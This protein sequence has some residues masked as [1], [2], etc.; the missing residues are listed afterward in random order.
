MNTQK[1][2][3]YTNMIHSLSDLFPFRCQQATEFSFMYFSHRKKFPRL[4]QKDYL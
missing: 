3:D 1:E 4:S 2:K